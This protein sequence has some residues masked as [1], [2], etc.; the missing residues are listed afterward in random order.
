MNGKRSVFISGG[1]PAGL[2]AALLFD[3]LGWDEIV[4]AER[5]PSP[6]DFEKNKSFNYL[7]DR[8][9]LRILERLGIA[10]RMYQCGVDTTNFTATTIAPD[11]SAETKVVPIIDPNRPTC[12]WTTR[13][14]FL[15]M[16][17]DAIKEKGS[18]R[19]KVFYG[20]SVSAIDRDELGHAQVRVRDREGTET[21]FKP[22]LIL[23]CDGLNSAIRK[24]L[25]RQPDVPK[26]HFDMI[27]GDS[28]STGL[29]YK[30]LN[31]PSQFTVGDGSVA[32]NDNRMSYIIPARHKARRKQCALFAFPVVDPSHPRSVN[33]I[34]EAD[35]ELWTLKSGEEL[36]AWMEDAF[37]QLDIRSL[38]SDEE[39]EDFVNLE[40]GAFPAPQYAR[41]LHAGLGPDGAKTQVLLIGD[42][43]HAFPPD[44][45]LGVNAA[46]Q[47]L[48]VLARQIDKG[49]DLA[50]TVANYAEERLPE[51]RDLVWIVERTFPEQYNHRPTRLKLWALGFFGRWGMHKLLPGVFDKPAFLLSQDPDMPYGEMKWRKLRTDIRY[52]G[53][54][55]AMLAAIAGGT[56]VALS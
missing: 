52:R 45:G 47:D 35:H 23:A 46:L 8:R 48:D 16:L 31:L 4:L 26:G 39:A 19:L 12:F 34:R 13:R 49:E 6:S 17:Y 15:T 9:G 50:A 28:I 1:G 33:L 5:R 53:L 27:A 54:V 51:A 14:A 20:H 18:E 22:D 10:D 43:A 44:L 40:A 41:N 55:A 25:E 38:V 7:V 32:V 56:A 42:A 21:S 3:Q 24:E 2:A 37:P 29:R 30:V 11:G 36:L